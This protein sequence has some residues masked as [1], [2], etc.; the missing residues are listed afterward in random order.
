MQSGRSPRIFGAMRLKTLLTVLCAA[1]PFVLSAAAHA[2]PSVTQGTSG[3][4]TVRVTGVSDCTHPKRT[5]APVG[6]RR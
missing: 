1:A 4:G 2:N 6:A 3:V 5:V